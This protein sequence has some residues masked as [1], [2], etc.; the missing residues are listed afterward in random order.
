[1]SSIRFALTDRIGPHH[2]ALYRAWIQ[3]LDLVPMGRRYIDED[4]PRRVRGVLQQLRARFAQAALRV[5]MPR[6]ARLLA[7]SLRKPAS[8]EATGDVPDLAAFQA[9]VDPDGEMGE[10]ELVELYRERYAPDARAA[11]AD[12]RR[13]RWIQQQ[14]QAL[15]WVESLLVTKPVPQ[16]PIDAWFEGSAVEHLRA[17]GIDTIERLMGYIAERGKT[18]YRSIEGVGEVV[19]QRIVQWLDD[20]STTLGPL[21]ESALVGRNALAQ[22]ALPSVAQ[23]ML[24]QAAQPGLEVGSVMPAREAAPACLIR[25]E[26]DWQALRAWIEAR[27]GSPHTARAYRREG[28]R[29]L[30]FLLREKSIGLRQVRTE[31]LT[32]YRTFLT[33]LGRNGAWPFRTPASEYLA[34]RNIPRADPRWRPFEGPLCA[35]SAQ[36]ALIIVRAWLEFLVNVRYLS[37]NPAA[38][39]SIK[40]AP[41]DMRS[42]TRGL[43]QA[44]YDL[45]VQCASSLPDDHDGDRLRFM[46]AL[47]YHSAARL[48]ELAQ[49]SFADVSL[50]SKEH[51]PGSYLMLGLRGKGNKIRAVWLPDEVQRLWIPYARHRGLD[52]RMSALKG[53]DIPLL[54]TRDGRAL[55]A[56]R[57]YKLIKELFEQAAKLAMDRGWWD[58]AAVIAQCSPHDLR[59]SRARHLGQQKLALPILQRM[60]G[61]A[62]LSTTSL[63]TTSSDLEMVQALQQLQA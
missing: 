13:E 3:G 27:A 7:V 21:P 33:L 11:A 41:D 23:R 40:L 63:Y 32:D 15:A 4:D 19:A 28:E 5:R 46:L 60:L 29:F 51:E 9:E 20:H 56:S 47:A 50:L 45:V 10:A 26:D 8:G 22:A 35:K 58:D 14:L 57:I 43:S 55:G 37:G 42:V 53:Q 18:W 39:L 38:G 16:D 48:S 17:R 54:A 2:M 62:S 49:A 30:L 34:P 44:Q 36:Q 24:Q 59:H 31:D 6:Y 12:K 25:A 52:V 61:H 1:M